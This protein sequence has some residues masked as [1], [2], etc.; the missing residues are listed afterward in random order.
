MFNAST[1]QI[2]KP[3][4]SLRELIDL[5]DKS[6]EFEYDVF[7]SFSQKNTPQVLEIANILRGYGLRV[8]VYFESIAE[9]VGNA[10]QTKISKALENSRH[11]IF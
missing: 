10:W 5:D 11:F 4:A 7:L 2:E 8:F 9:N 3:K 1:A 6:I